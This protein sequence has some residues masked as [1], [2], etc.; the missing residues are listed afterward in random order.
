[1]GLFKDFGTY[2][3]KL[4][5]TIASFGSCWYREAMDMLLKPHGDDGEE[6]LDDDSQTSY[7]ISAWSQICKDRRRRFEQF[8]RLV[9]GPVMKTAFIK[10][11]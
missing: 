11:K 5:Q 10:P 4:L 9:M 1:M 3:L 7:L 6:L 8:L 2:R